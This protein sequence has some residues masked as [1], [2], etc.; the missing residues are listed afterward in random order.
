[1]RLHSSHKLWCL[2]C[3]RRQFDHLER[4]VV[5]TA[6]VIKII[7]LD[8]DIVSS[9]DISVGP[10]ERFVIHDSREHCCLT[11]II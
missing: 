9:K 11:A 8:I 2:D 4:P 3:L 7:I 6:S 1:M 5:E 10:S